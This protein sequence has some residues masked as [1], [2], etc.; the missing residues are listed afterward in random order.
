MI[1][2]AMV[3]TTLA[4]S[5][6]VM[7]SFV[8][9]DKGWTIENLRH[10][11]KDAIANRVLIF[12]VS[13]VVMACVL[14]TLHVRGMHIDKAIDMAFRPYRSWASSQRRCSGGRNPGRRPVLGLSQCIGFNL[15]DILT[16]S[17][18]C[19]IPGRGIFD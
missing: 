9:T 3:G 6:V 17:G 7:R 15:A 2:A 8:V 11:N 12:V 13:A 10:A 16:I 4:G 5:V 1:A 14:A 19:V 18:C